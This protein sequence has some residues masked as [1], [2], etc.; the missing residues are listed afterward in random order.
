MKLVSFLEEG[1]W[2]PGVL[3]DDSVVAIDTPH[4]T[5]AEAIAAF[6]RDGRLA[7]GRPRPAASL[8][9]GL[10]VPNPGKIIC[11]G[12]NYRE[13]AREGGNPIPDYPA[14]FL[15]ALTSLIPHGAPLI[16]PDASDKLDYEAE[17]AVIIGARARKVAEG[18][19]LSRVFGYSCFN[20]GS[21]RDYQRKSSQWTVGKNFDGTGAF[22]PHVT[23]ADE[24][25]PGATDLGIRTR[26]NG[27]VM[28]NGNTS[29]M[30]FSIARLI[31]IASEAMTLEPGDIIITG[32][33]SGVG[34]ARKP[35]VFLKAGDVCEIEI[36]G[37]GTL[38]NPVARA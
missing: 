38:R 15:R 1:E 18:D 26:L 19:A 8:T 12:L 9:L 13:H 22:G 11:I 36:D 23:T 6:M 16:V 14:I 31:A 4:R 3:R 30:I 33:P 10:P 7:E 34:Y 28:Q 24:L 35:P 21:V 17:L 25:P 2:R 37:I 29:D 5:T 27:A 20:D 32:T